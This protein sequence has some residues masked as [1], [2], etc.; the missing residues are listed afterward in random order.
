MVVLVIV[1]VTGTSA[2]PTPATGP[3]PTPAPAAVVHDVTAIPEAVFD[4]VGVTS[5]DAAVTPPSLL[6][7]QRPLE[8]TGKPEVVFVGDEFC[9]YCAAERWAV[10]AALARFG[11]WHGLDAIQS[12][13]DEAFPATPTFTFVSARYT[14][15]YVT[16]KLIE[17][18]GDQ[19][20]SA[21]TSY[22]VLERLPRAVQ[23]LMAEYDRPTPGLV[24]F[25]DIANRAVVAGGVFSPAVLQQLTTT[26]IA[27]G[28]TDPKDPATQAIVASANY[29][30][31]VMCQAD[32]GLP[33]RVCTSAGVT[34][35]ASALSLRS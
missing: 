35:A 17:H 1:K 16:A 24:P 27:G 31:A 23:S 7:G 14:S 21:G 9:P 30:S 2:T 25:L 29:L 8:E 5:T 20:N 28:L 19:Q 4:A 32:G 34:A 18:Y 26:D 22:T 13:S 33:S 3:P 6:A 11:T 12:G 10:V 15:P